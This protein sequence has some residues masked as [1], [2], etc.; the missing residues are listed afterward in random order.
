MKFV[1][2]TVA[3]VEKL[4]SRA[5]VLKRKFKI[6]HREALER[7]ARE[8]SYLHWHHVT[9]CQQESD[10]K[11]RH[12]TVTFLC[13]SMT[14]DALKGETH[15]LAFFEPVPSVLLANGKQT[16]ALIASESPDCLILVVEGQEVKWA[17][18]GEGEDTKIA[19]NATYTL[20]TDCLVATDKVTGA[21]HRIPI[22]EGLL[23]DRIAQSTETYDDKDFDLTFH[24]P[25]N[26][27]AQAM[28]RQIFMGEGLEPI[29]DANK[30]ILMSKS[31]S[32][33]MINEAI[34]AGAQFSRPRQS[35]IYPIM[36]SDD[37]EE[38]A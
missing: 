32:E 12:L 22:D 26:P 3:D 13:E 31:Y 5:K 4:K 21:V 2:T 17:I 10:R 20:E 37:I 30:A 11:A 28:F 1:P 15:Y 8:A 27:D 24:D 9:L 34:A 14:K 38:E 36:S 7:A 35:M 25:D 6:K 33:E 19:W 16:G 23:N 18:E 29:D